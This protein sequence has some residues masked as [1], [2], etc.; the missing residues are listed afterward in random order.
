VQVNED[1]WVCGA[2]LSSKSVAPNSGE[3]LRSDGPVAR[4]KP[5]TVANRPLHALSRKAGF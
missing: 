3:P 1:I 4:W 5:E 2:G